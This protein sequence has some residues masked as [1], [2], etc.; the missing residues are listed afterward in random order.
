ML[1][2]AAAALAR[3]D[4]SPIATLSFLAAQVDFNEPG[5]LQLFINE[6]QLN[7]LDDMMWE[8]GFLDA[9][10]MAGAFQLLRSN[11]LIW[12]RNMREYMLGERSG[13]FDL[14]AWNADSTRMPYR[15]HSEYLRKL[16]LNNDFAEGRFVVDGRPVTIADINAPMF[17]VGTLRDHVAPWQSVYKS[18]LLADTEITFL[19]TSGGH[20]AGVVSEPGHPHRSYQVAETSETDRYIDPD[21][22]AAQTPKQDGS[23]W[24]EWVAWLDKRS[25]KPVAPPQMGA[26][27]KGYKPIADAPGTYVMQK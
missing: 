26:P 16:Y 7:F 10:Q 11:D 9:K 22:W 25:G 24:P 27:D 14:M 17:S 13:L 23:W 4:H 2:I 19:L 5:E 8:Q 20:N 18:H 15:M 21:T 12:S 6:S 3:N 1:A